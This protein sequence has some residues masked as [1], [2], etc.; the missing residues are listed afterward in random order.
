[1]KRVNNNNRILHR[2]C[3]VPSGSQSMANVLDVGKCILLFTHSFI[4]IFIKHLL[5][6]NY[7][8]SPKTTGMKDLSSFSPYEGAQSPAEE[9]I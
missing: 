8:L 1:M 6:T 7:E 2:V 4:H 3:S 9:I 5:G